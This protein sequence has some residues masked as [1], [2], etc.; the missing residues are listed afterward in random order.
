VLL[1]STSFAAARL[2]ICAPMWTASQFEHARGAVAKIDGEDRVGTQR[3]LVGGVVGGERRREPSRGAACRGGLSRSR[4][5]PS[6]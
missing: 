5:L 1:T 6:G 3:V 2:L 4:A